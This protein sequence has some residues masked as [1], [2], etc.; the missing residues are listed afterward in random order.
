MSKE[1]VMFGYMNTRVT[2][3]KP[4]SCDISSCCGRYKQTDEMFGEKLV[5]THVYKC[6]RCGDYIRYKE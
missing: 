5:V 6:N 2:Q 3:L 1:N 4:D